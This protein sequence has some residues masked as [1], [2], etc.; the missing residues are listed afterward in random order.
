MNRLYTLPFSLTILAASAFATMTICSLSVAAT[1]VLKT[2]L[3]RNEFVWTTNPPSD[4]RHQCG[5]GC[6]G[7]NACG[8]K[9]QDEPASCAE[10]QGTVCQIAATEIVAPA[11]DI[12]K[13][14]QKDSPKV[15]D[16]IPSASPPESSPVP[17]PSSPS[18]DHGSNDSDANDSD[19]DNDSDSES[20]P[21]R[22]PKDQVPDSQDANQGQTIDLDPDSVSDADESPDA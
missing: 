5:G 2:E 21:N 16:L 1:D 15:A 19:R 7:T 8:K 14:P 11:P 6:C 12:A 10:G 20:D 22:D 17:T 4:V 9:S 18:D 13:A 3:E